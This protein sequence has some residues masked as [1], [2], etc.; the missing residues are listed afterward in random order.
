MTL[1]SYVGPVHSNRF[2]SRPVTCSMITCCSAAPRISCFFPPGHVQSNDDDDDDDDDDDGCLYT[3]RVPVW[4]EAAQELVGRATERASRFGEGRNPGNW[5]CHETLMVFH[6]W[7]AA[8][9]QQS[10]TLAMSWDT[11]LFARGN[12]PPIPWWAA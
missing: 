7:A 9:P 12:P 10:R 8:G 2:Q 1:L 5:P 4:V 11:N 3:K 6:R